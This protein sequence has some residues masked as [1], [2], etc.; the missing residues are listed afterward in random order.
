[1]KK[2]PAFA[3]AFLVEVWSGKLEFMGWVLAIFDWV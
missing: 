1:M 2:A 3:G